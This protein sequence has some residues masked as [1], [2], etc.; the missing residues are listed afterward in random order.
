MKE[1]YRQDA[2]EE[3]KEEGK[4]K[5]AEGEDDGDFWAYRGW[6]KFYE[7]KSDDFPDKFLINSAF[8]Y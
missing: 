1:E 3:K 8:E 7:E 6:L 2:K 5:A 4:D